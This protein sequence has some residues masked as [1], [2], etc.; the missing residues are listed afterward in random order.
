MQR[1]QL[2]AT[3]YFFFLPV[4]IVIHARVI[5]IFF[6]FY[7][8]ELLVLW[9]TFI[10]VG[11]ASLQLDFRRSILRLTSVFGKI[12]E[13]WPVLSIQFGGWKVTDLRV[14]LESTCCMT[15]HAKKFRR[16]F[17]KFSRP[18]RS[19]EAKLFIIPMDHLPS[20]GLCFKIGIIGLY[21]SL[22]S[23]PVL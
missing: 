22:L 13:H 20:A 5:T 7:G 15:D 18:S 14:F 8:S 1:Q 17:A 12:N 4:S 23:C 6:F 3:F 21:S 2:N 19:S 11:I 16:D 10:V 9:Q